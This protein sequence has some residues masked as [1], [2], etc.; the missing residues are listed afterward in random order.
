M[1]AG[2][3]QKKPK[4][5]I[6]VQVSEAAESL[7][8]EL[9]RRGFA[10]TDIV[11]RMVRFFEGADPRVREAILHPD[12]TYESVASVIVQVKLGDLVSSNPSAAKSIANKLTVAQSLAVARVMLDKTEQIHARVSDELGRRYAGDSAASE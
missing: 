12:S 2:I 9:R 3:K 11:E 1:A 7:L 6:T 5:S 8:G 10:K 4:G